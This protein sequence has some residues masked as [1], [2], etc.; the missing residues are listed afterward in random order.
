MLLIKIQTTCCKRQNSQHC[1][2]LSWIHKE[3]EDNKLVVNSFFML[4][5]NIPCGNLWELALGDQYVI[6]RV[7]RTNISVH[8][9]RPLQQTYTNTYWYI[10]SM[11]ACWWLIALMSAQTD[12]QRD[13]LTDRQTDWQTDSTLSL[14][15]TG[16]FHH[17]WASP[18]AVGQNLSKII[19]SYPPP[20]YSR[21]DPSFLKR[22]SLW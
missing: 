21:R 6:R 5:S 3:K 11:F 1:T 13:I 22:Y 20:F 14:A 9:T 15:K 17:C 10:F 18:A 2:C 7:N 8:L 4:I 16:L 12:R 19:F